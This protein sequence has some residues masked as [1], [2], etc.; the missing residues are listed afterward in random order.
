MLKSTTNRNDLAIANQIVN[1]LENIEPELR[2][3]KLAILGSETVWALQSSIDFENNEDADNLILRASKL[4]KN[5][6]KIDGAD[7]D[8]ENIRNLTEIYS[9]FSR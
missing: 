8:I 6:R 3:K 4:L 5:F 9:D 1:I 2:T 7:L